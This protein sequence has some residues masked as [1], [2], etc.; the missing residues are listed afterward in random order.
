MRESRRA[1]GARSSREQV[2]GGQLEPPD[3]PSYKPTGAFSAVDTEK[4]TA[5]VGR[6]PQRCAELRTLQV[7]QLRAD[8]TQEN[9][10]LLYMPYERRSSKEEDGEHPRTPADEFRFRF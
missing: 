10:R 3:V 9:F 2:R 5:T 7:V 8:A 4:N 1:R 6:F